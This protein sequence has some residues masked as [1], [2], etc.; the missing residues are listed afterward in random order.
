MIKKL[1]PERNAKKNEISDNSSRKKKTHQNTN[2][3]SCQ[4][5]TGKT[6]S[7][8]LINIMIMFVSFYTETHN[9]TIGKMVTPT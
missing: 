2:I 3:T 9:K 7:E 6:V 1:L 5:S 8:S 4:N